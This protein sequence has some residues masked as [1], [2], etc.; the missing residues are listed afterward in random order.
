MKPGYL[1]VVFIAIS[2]S[3]CMWGTHPPK[4]A[5]IAKDTLHYVYQTFKERADDC[6]NK[7]DSN[8]TVVKF[9]YP[10]FI[11]QTTLND[12]V[13]NKLITIF[14]S[15]KKND[16]SFEQ[17][18]KS[19]LTNYKS[20]KAG[21]SSQSIYALN[22][23]AKILRQDSDLVTLQVYAYSFEGGAHPSSFTYFI[24]WDTKTDKRIALNSLFKD[25]D[26][27]TLKTIAEAIFRKSEKLSPKASLANDYFFKNNQFAL[28][29]NY[30]ITP[31]G[32]RFLYNEYEIKPYVAGTTSLF[33]PYTQI[34]SLLRP[35]TVLSQYIK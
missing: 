11:K 7:A 9:I 27:D 33:I 35:N 10:V 29:N 18:A 8:C 5:A 12:S 24:N 1:A 23:N 26:Q 20:L 21:S 28:N 6:G 34:K 15:G 17:L 4:N 22:G 25:N 16:T 30:L 31:L 13:I 14:P 19:F 2:L 3:S 32:I